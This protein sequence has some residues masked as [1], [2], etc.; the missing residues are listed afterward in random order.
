MSI[1]SPF[2]KNSTPDSSANMSE[3]ALKNDIESN[4]GL[5][6]EV[7][8]EWGLANRATPKTIL[9]LRSI[10]TYPEHLAKKLS[11]KQ[12]EFVMAKSDAE[13]VRQY[14][15]LV[16]RFNEELEWMKKAEN[17]HRANQLAQLAEGL[18]AQKRRKVRQ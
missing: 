15:E 10:S 14:D 17:H 3:D 5:L 7:F 4:G 9:N 6:N 1:N 12:V 2:A 11:V 16:T 8:D 13:K 18:R